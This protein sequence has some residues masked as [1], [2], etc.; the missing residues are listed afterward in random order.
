[1]FIVAAAFVWRICLPNRYEEHRFTL[2]V[3]FVDVRITVAWIYS[4]A[5]KDVEQKA[6]AMRYEWLLLWEAEG[7]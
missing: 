2:R 1:M 6:S 4:E 3:G 5:E 7:G